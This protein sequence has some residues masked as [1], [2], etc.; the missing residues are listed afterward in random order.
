M[1]AKG[2][3]ASPLAKGYSEGT[4]CFSTIAVIQLLVFTGLGM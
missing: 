2:Y 3:H 4:G 1:E